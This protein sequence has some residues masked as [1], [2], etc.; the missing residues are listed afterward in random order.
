MEATEVKWKAK[1]VLVRRTKYKHKHGKVWK[2]SAYCMDM[3]TPSQRN[4]ANVFSY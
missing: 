2:V 3:A 4:A 1:D